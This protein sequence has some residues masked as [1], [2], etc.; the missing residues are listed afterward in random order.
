MNTFSS[1]ENESL[2]EIIGF[3][4]M[5]FKHI[6]LGINISI[7]LNLNLAILCSLK[8]SKK[9]ES[10]YWITS[11]TLPFVFNVPV[12]AY[13]IF[14]RNPAGKCSF[15][16]GPHA[17]TA[18]NLI[19]N[20]VFSFL[21]IGY[22]LVIS[23]LVIYRVRKSKY[24]HSIENLTSSA[25]P[26]ANHS[27]LS[28]KNLI[29]RTCLYP[30]SC[31]LTYLGDNIVISY[32][33]LFKEHPKFLLYWAR[34]GVF[35]RGLLHLIAFLSDPMVIQAISN[36]LNSNE[37]LDGYQIKP[38]SHFETPPSNYGFSY[39]SLVCSRSDGD[40]HDFDRNIKDFRQFI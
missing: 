33:F 9:W 35:S 14:G 34:L 5:L 6:Y 11:F 36:R 38:D 26:K 4:T 40:S 39:E 17:S 37:E 18:L 1:A 10:F 30:A 22:C 16:Y 2:C 3:L 27:V 32:F 12:L 24:G 13:G 20:A 21:T 29:C 8:P 25:N 28:L 19:Y 15:K 23:L 31:F 7:A